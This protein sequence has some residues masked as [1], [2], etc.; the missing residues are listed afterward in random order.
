MTNCW[1]GSEQIHVFGQEYGVCVTCGTLVY[2]KAIPPEALVVLNDETDYYGKKYWLEH[3]EEDFGY[4]DLYTR[5]RNDLTERNPYWLKTLLKYQLPPAKVLEVGCAHGSFVALL[6]QAGY[7]A[8]GIE[9]SPWIVEFGKKTFDVP[10]LLGPIEALDIPSGSLD[11]I[12][13]MDVLEHLP[14][15][16]TTM[17]QCFQLLKPDGLLLIQ[18]PQFKTEMNYAELVETKGV[19][20]E[21]LKAVE[22]LYLFSES[23][24]TQLF[25]QLGAEHMQFETAI[26]DYYD[27]FFVVSR[28]S[29]VRVPPGQVESVLLSTSKGR[30]SLALL[31]MDA[32]AEALNKT[33]DE[34][35]NFKDS[36]ISQV[37]TLTGWIEEARSEMKERQSSAQQQIETLTEWVV[38]LEDRLVTALQKNEI[39]AGIVPHIIVKFA[40]TLS[41]IYEDLTKKIWR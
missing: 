6:R 39:L 8:D 9:M 21:Q 33:I 35:Q 12:F 38:L 14:D 10:I 2:I 11:V 29:I 7:N 3:Q 5:T 17:A 18:T 24:A 25:Q 30:F 31:D 34:L 36:A 32:K 28:E 16:L 27:M 37:N 13:L 15:P 40:H 20:L 41:T 19:F 1:C 4:D 23:S 22:H 26:F